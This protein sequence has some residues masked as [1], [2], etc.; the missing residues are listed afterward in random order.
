MIDVDWTGD[1]WMDVLVMRFSQIREIKSAL[2]LGRISISSRWLLVS[3]EPFGTPPVGY[4][5]VQLPMDKKNGPI[6]SSGTEW[7][8]RRTAE[9]E[10]EWKAEGYE[11]TGSLR[12]HLPEPQFQDWD[13][14]L[15]WA[16][17]T[18]DHLAATPMEED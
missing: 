13:D 3:K 7:I 9:L 15:Q 16:A 4:L 6:S 5:L 8:D 2:G 12:T 18:H 10:E 11:Y 17:D 1:A 14:L